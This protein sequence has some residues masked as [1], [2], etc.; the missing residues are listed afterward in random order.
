M[1]DLIT[2]NVEDGP[3]EPPEEPPEDPPGYHTEVT[4]TTSTTTEVRNRKT[5]EYSDA[6]GQITIR[7]HDQDEKSLDG[8]LFKIDVAFDDLYL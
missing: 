6:V 2:Y 3:T 5:Y 8:A 7:K 1:Q 4:T